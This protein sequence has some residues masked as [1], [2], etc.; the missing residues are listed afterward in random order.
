MKIIKQELPGFKYAFESE[1]SLDLVEFC[2]YIRSQVGGQ[3]FYW[4][5]PEKKWRFNDLNI[6]EMLQGRYIDLDIDPSMNDDIKLW[7]LQTEQDKI[8]EKKCQT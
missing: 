1:Y 6:F 3:A 7:K 4:D 2:R 8:I 5:A